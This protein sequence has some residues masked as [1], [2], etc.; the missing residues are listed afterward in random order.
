[1]GRPY[2]TDLRE[3]AVAR[4][5]TADCRA[6]R[7]PLSS[8]LGSARSSTGSGGFTRR[9]ALRR[10][11]WAATS[12]RPS[13]AGTRRFCPSAFGRAPSRSAG[14]CGTRR[15]R[16]QGRLSLGLELRPRGEAQLQKKGSW[17]AN[18]TGPT[19]RD[20]GRNGRSVRTRS[21]PSVWCSLTRPGRRPIWSRLADGRRGARGWW[22][23]LPT[24][25][26]KP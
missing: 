22:P 12:R 15:P 24:A 2:S 21:R 23:A 11:R 25:I 5:C 1:M 10:A 18:A 26:G 20:G 13:A 3:R 8:P 6:T 4:F 16:P 14:W 19:S 7:R 17:R 9:A